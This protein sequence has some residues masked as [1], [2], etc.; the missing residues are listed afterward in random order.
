MNEKRIMVDWGARGRYAEEEG[1]RVQKWRTKVAGT[2]AYFTIV[3]PIPL[4][5]Y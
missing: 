2:V 3:P 4:C 1:E 5:M